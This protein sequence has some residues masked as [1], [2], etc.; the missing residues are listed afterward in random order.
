VVGRFLEHSRVY[1]FENGGSREIYIGSA[2]LMERNLDRRVEVLC[3]LLDPAI[4]DKIGQLLRMYLR[5]DTKAT[6]LAPDGRYEAVHEQ[7]A[8]SIDAQ[9]MLMAARRS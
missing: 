9:E 6:A 5:D 1:A 3:P 7:R 4:R 8:G 2:D